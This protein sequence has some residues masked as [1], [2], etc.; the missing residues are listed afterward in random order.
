MIYFVPFVLLL[1]SLAQGAVVS[2][3]QALSDPSSFV[4]KRN[5]I[6][7]RMGRLGK[8]HS[9]T[10]PGIPLIAKRD[11][12]IVV[13]SSDAPGTEKVTL[14]KR[15]KWPGFVVEIAQK[16]AGIITNSILAQLGSA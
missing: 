7:M 14:S 4:V 2:P 6:S 1:S 5:R 8:R 3:A 12:P 16:V 9:L 13:E 15:Q 10:T 11:T